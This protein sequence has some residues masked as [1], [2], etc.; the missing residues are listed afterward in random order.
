[1]K[2]SAFFKKAHIGRLGISEV[3]QLKKIF[4]L[5]P[6]VCIFYFCKNMNPRLYILFLADKSMK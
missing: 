5:F 1:M 3:K 6:T 4:L 2:H